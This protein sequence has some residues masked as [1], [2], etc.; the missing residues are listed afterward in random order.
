V[1]GGGNGG[2]RWVKLIWILRRRGTEVGRGM[3]V[4]RWK[5]EGE[6]GRNVT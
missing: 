1:E 5:N 6:R 3:G 2:W 4:R